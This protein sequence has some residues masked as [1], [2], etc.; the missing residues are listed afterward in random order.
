MP[1]NTEDFV[2]RFDEYVSAVGKVAHAWNYLQ[3]GLGQMFSVLM[4]PAPEG[5]SLAVWHSQQNDRAQR[6]MFRAAIN[7]GV[8]KHVSVTLPDSAEDDLLWLLKE[9]DDLSA[10]RDEAIHAPCSIVTGEGGAELSA[11]AAFYWGNP[12]AQRLVG[13][14]LIEEFELSEWRASEL[15]RYAREMDTALLRGHRRWPDKRPTLS[16]AAFAKRNR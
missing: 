11:A 4:R 14:N 6:R 12:L 9:A 15:I 10:R 1:P 13:K 5:V 2:R 7:A 3:E 8:L 16:R